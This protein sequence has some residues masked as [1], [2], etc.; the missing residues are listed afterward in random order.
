MSTMTDTISEASAAWYDWREQLSERLPGGDLNGAVKLEQMILR[1][2]K[3][4]RC[5][6]CGDPGAVIQT[7]SAYMQAVDFYYL[8]DDCD[9][10]FEGSV[11]GMTYTV[12]GQ[13]GRFEARI[14]SVN[15][16]RTAERIAR[17]FDGKSRVRTNG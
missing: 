4:C 5:A 11:G 13:S 10:H 3:E 1:S 16:K 7:T 17:D 15:N 9:R 8:C 6:E 2:K 12:L 14:A